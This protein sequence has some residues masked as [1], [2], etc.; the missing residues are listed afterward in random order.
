MILIVVAMTATFVRKVRTS[1]ARWDEAGAR[2]ASARAFAISSSLLW[3]MIIVC[4]RLIGY[5][6]VLYA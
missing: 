4:G 5:T 1:A 6:W 2:P 3:I